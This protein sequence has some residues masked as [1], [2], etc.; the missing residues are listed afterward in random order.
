MGRARMRV[1]LVGCGDVAGRLA[2][3]LVDRFTVFGL[4]RGASSGEKTSGQSN[5]QKWRALGVQPVWGD[6][7]VKHSLKRLAGLADIVVHLAP[8]PTS[9]ARDTR[10][11]NLIAALAQGRILP[12]RVVY[13]ST[14]GVYG[15][16]AGGKVDETTP[17]RPTTARAKRRVDAEDALRRFAARTGAALTILRAP[18]IYA[19]DRLPIARLEAGTPALN[20]DEDSHTNHIHADD[21]ARAIWHVLVE[22]RPGGRRGRGG[23][24]YNVS[25]DSAL[26][27]GDYFDLVADHF[28]L[29][30][31]KRISR[32]E[33]EATLP[34]GLLSFMRESRQIINTRLTGELRFVLRYPTVAHSLAQLNKD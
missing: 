17:R 1:L 3:L 12:K 22:A 8:P 34:E 21:L 2:P 27:M 31:P 23:R 30:R 16:A 14:T 25:D 10:T 20:A 26:K 19:A 9:G 6:L 28:A 18:G 29:P 32:R 4:L 15:D 5:G 11:R 7:D 33:A 24:A 13:I